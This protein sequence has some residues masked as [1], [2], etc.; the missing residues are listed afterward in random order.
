MA[1]FVTHGSQ[2]PPADNGARVA[3]KE[4]GLWGGGGGGGDAIRQVWEIQKNLSIS[5]RIENIL[6]VAQAGS[7]DKNMGQ[8]S[9]WTVPLSP[10]VL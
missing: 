4:L 3:R 8:K 6:S 7:N 1:H 9:R 2:A 10:N 5:A